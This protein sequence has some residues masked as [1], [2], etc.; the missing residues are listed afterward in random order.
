MIAAI[1]RMLGRIA[2]RLERFDEAA[3]KLLRP[4]V[5]DPKYTQAQP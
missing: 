5:A 4:L 3:A 2:S 1:H